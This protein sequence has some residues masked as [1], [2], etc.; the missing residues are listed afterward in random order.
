MRPRCTRFAIDAAELSPIGSSKGLRPVTKVHVVAASAHTSC[1]GEAGEFTS[2]CSGGAHS[3]EK[4]SNAP[5]SS[6][7]TFEATPK[8]ASTGLPYASSMMLDGLI[9]RCT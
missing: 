2:C 9:S 1:R 8:S 3:T 6:C 4:P 5:T 7:P